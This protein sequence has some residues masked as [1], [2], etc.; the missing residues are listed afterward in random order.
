MYS[1]R[2]PS[3]SRMIPLDKLRDPSS[4]PKL[5]PTSNSAH[6]LST[7][8]LKS[9]YT[10]VVTLGSLLPEDTLH[11]GDDEEFRTLVEG[12]LVGCEQLMELA[13]QED[14]SGDSMNIREVRP[15]SSL[16]KL[17]V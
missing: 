12:C 16:L 1:C 2:L 15:L 13:V 7:S 17:S 9:F 4:P 5:L 11:I 14:L 10:H 6:P 3:L 8:L